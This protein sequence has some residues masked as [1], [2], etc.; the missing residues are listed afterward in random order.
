MFVHYLNQ[1]IN[2]D[3]IERVICDD[4]VGLG[5]VYVYLI[6][7]DPEVDEAAVVHGAEATNLIMTLCPAV[8]EGKQAKYR[9]HA[10]AIHNLIGHPLMQLLSWIGLT[11]LGIK[12]HDATIPEEP[13]D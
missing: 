9:R 3:R 13:H 2:A 11:R 10:W 7:Q 6:G 12:V 1:I 8:L 4:Y 5:T